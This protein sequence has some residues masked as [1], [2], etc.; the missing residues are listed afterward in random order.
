MVAKSNAPRVFPSTLPVWVREDPLRSAECKVYDCFAEQLDSEFTVFYSRPW[1]GLAKDGSE[2]D[3]EADFVVAH[4]VFGFI[5]I[6]VKGGAVAYDATSD[7]WSSRDRYAIVHR[8]KNPVRQAR[9]SKYRILEKLHAAAG[10]DGRRI[11]ARHGVVLPDSDR[12]DSD[13]GP[14]MP[15]E[16][17]A[18]TQDMGTLRNW[19]HGR[20]GIQ[21]PLSTSRECALGENGL[22]IFENLLARSFQLR[23]PLLRVVQAEEQHIVVLT[24][25]Q[26]QILD[27]FENYSRLAIAGGAG[28]GKTALAIEKAR[29]TALAGKRTLLTC[30]NRPLGAFL[31]EILSDQPAVVVMTFHELC[32]VSAKQ[33]SITIPEVDTGKLFGEVLPRALEAAMAMEPRLGFDAI[34]VDEGQDFQPT[35]WPALERSLAD[36]A[37]GVLFVF[38][39]DH[40]QLY[41]WPSTYL[42][43]MPQAPFRLTRNVRNTKQIFDEAKPYF[44]K[45]LIRPAGPQGLPVEHLEAKTQEKALQLISSLLD[46]L[47][48]QEK[49]VPDHIAI[50]AE[51]DDLS[52]SLAPKGLLGRHRVCRA[53][54]RA[55]SAIILDSVRRFKGLESP[56]VVVVWSGS[57]IY[58]QELAYVGLTRARSHLIVIRSNLG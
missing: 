11:R 41:S 2:V 1:L 19:L 45:S 39:D 26:F 27:G 18:F 29:R 55:K 9:T 10:W 50:L 48:D 56:V 8:I 30:Y 57:G 40:Q 44:G 58:D 53:D 23:T 17:F 52:R 42:G 20:M 33:A 12:P 38:Y 43:G 13:L 54:A 35:W 28:T 6:E 5:A 24:D 47:V 37:N 15:L 31:R 49:I 16:L 46:R 3:G 14:D 7:E 51:T 36:P 4:Q 21:T 32:S 25:E 22:I 34:I